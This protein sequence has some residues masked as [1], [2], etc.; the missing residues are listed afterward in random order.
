[1]NNMELL[2]KSLNNK[3]I[4]KIAFLF[5]TLENP[6]FPE[7]WDQYF[8]GHES[9]YTI[10]IHPKYPEKLTWNKNRMIKNL[11]ETEWGKITEAYIELLK[12][13]YKDKNN[14][15]FVT[16][17]ESCVPIKSFS[18]FYRDCINDSSCW[19]KIM[20]MSKYD[21][22]ERIGKQEIF[23][24]KKNLIIPSKFIKHYARFCL[25][26][27]TVKELLI[28][29]EKKLLEFFHKMKVGDEFFLSVLDK[30][31]LKYKNF[32]VTFDDW[33][34]V[35]NQKKNIKNKLQKLYLKEREAEKF[36][37]K[38]ELKKYQ[39]KILELNQTFKNIAKS[40]KTI[41]NVTKN[42]DLLKIK[43]CNSYFYRKFSK[44]SNIK[45]YWKN[46]IN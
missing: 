3:P 31:K 35:H 13:A 27:E 5:L 9:E 20:N 6:N 22:I 23:A 43:K 34:Y 8:K 38:E 29:N 28:K 18:K 26:R 40:P 17:S 44:D 25:N 41:I 7:I 30:N 21:R 16:I 10:Y 1:M 36:N 45:E 14:Y 4:K 42:N 15:K 24:A 32:E 33:D 19:I 39:N 46:I 12:E 37:E 2:S 11:K